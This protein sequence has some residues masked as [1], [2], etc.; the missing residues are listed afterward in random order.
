MEQENEKICIQYS[1]EYM[2]EL[3]AF[4]KDLYKRREMLVG[5]Q[6]LKRSVLDR[7]PKDIVEEILLVLD[8]KSNQPAEV[9]R[10]LSFVNA[11]V[12]VRVV[13][14]YTPIKDSYIEQMP[15]TEEN[16]EQEVPAT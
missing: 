7:V 2:E 10:F 1:K 15:K 6:K 12:V 14:K 13:S 8:K 9:R 3:K 4:M 11:Q 16:G 5:K